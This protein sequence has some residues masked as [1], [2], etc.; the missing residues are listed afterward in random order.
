MSEIQQ[1]V[2]NVMNWD[3]S[4]LK[5]KMIDLD[6]PI[7]ETIDDLVRY[8]VS[9][10]QKDTQTITIGTG[11]V[12]LP[13]NKKMKY[14]CPDEKHSYVRLRNSVRRGIDDGDRIP[15]FLNLLDENVDKISFRMR[16]SK[17]KFTAIK[18]CDNHAG[19]F[20]TKVF[21]EKNQ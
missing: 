6:L 17:S 5:N 4:K 8:L 13:L 7:G 14:F 20:R 12:A 9:K 18:C 1:D 2:F 19:K 21:F 15:V 3:F 11:E 16:S 10:H